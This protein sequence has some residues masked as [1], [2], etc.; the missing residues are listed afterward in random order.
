MDGSGRGNSQQ[1]VRPTGTRT[2]L[3]LS[4]T[5]DE[6]ILIDGGIRVTVFKIERNK[7]RIAIEAPPETTI[8][9]E[10]LLKEMRK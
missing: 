2:R 7:V 1:P 9:R 3:I 4:R 10:E 6:S 8:M 5:K